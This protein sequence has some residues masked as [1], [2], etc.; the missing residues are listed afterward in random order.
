M[1]LPALPIAVVLCWVL[2]ARPP[3]ESMSAAKVR[4]LLDDRR[5]LVETP[6]RLAS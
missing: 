4:R 5:L 6:R 1:G 3:S 2:L